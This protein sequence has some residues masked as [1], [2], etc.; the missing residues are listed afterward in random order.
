M[1]YQMVSERHAPS[2]RIASPKDAFNALTRYANARCERFIVLT[3]DGAHQLIASRIISMGLVNRTVVHP[4]EVFFPAIKDNAVAIIVAHNHPSGR[5][6]PSPE[7]LEITRR[8]RESGEILGISLL[9][10]VVFHK[11]TG[12]YSFVEHGLLSPAIES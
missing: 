10:H 12:F 1:I 4:R 7:D 8:L 3:L 9:D 5:L 6:D 11:K 2:Y